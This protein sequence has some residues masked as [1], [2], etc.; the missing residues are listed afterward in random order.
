MSPPRIVRGAE[1]TPVPWRNG[2]GT[3]RDVLTAPAGLADWQV[4]IADLERDAPFSDFAG[5][6]RTFTIIE[7]PGVELTFG[8]VAVP[9]PPL[10]P[11]R[12][13]GGAA[14]ACRL[15]G[16]PGRAFNVFADARRFRSRVAVLRLAPD[17]GLD[18]PPGTTLL[19][20]IEG[21]LHVDEATLAAGDTLMEGG[22]TVR[23]QAGTATLV[24]VAIAA[25]GD[26][27]G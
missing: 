3:T 22:G 16:G 8:A 26:A 2:M 9:C 27:A 7:G 17:T 18:V 21:T 23:T 13:P 6:D 20:C 10:V 15:R 12:F 25:R 4:S 24:R 11:V 1:L 5:M 14:P 19:H